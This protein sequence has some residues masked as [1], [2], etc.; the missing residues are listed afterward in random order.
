MSRRRRILV[1]ESDERVR[2]DLEQA[3][4]EAGFDAVTTAEFLE[5]VDLL[6]SWE[7]DLV[8]VG[9]QPRQQCVGELLHLMREM[10]H[11]VRGLALLPRTAAE[12]RDIPRIGVWPRPEEPWCDEILKVVARRFGR[13]EAQGAA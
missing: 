8:L 7:F 6:Y 5:A 3:L 2:V 9:G 4:I 10:Q 11:P 12:A 1:L 13:Q